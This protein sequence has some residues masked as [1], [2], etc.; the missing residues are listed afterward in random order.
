M[1]DQ[2]KRNPW[3]YVVAAL[4]VMLL[5][6]V[7]AETTLPGIVRRKMLQPY[8]QL[9][10]Q[11]ASE[12]D[13]I[14]TH[15]RPSSVVSEPKELRVWFGCFAPWPDVSDRFAPWPDVSD[16]V[17][18]KVLIYQKDPLFPISESWVVYVFIDPQG[19][20]TQVALGLT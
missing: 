6:E 1:N 17:E 9:V 3:K 2:K 16:R 12:A 20:V 14:A 7:F 19:I 4:V 5:F 15:G 8:T 18:S 11:H 10:R 13:V